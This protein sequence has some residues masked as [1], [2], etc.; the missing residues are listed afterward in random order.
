[1]IQKR[2]D[3]YTGSYNEQARGTAQIMQDINI[4]MLWMIT[5]GQGADMQTLLEL[6]YRHILY[7]DTFL[8]ENGQITGEFLGGE[9]DEQ[10]I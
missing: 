8:I 5:Q 3:K 10:S 7:G 2:I 4:D 6:Y 9:D 1:M